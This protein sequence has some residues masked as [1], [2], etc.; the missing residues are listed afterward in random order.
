MTH[1]ELKKIKGSSKNFIKTE[2]GYIDWTF[3]QV[4]MYA[5]YKRA[6]E[7]VDQYKGSA[8]NCKLRNDYKRI[9]QEGDCWLFELQYT[10][11][12]EVMLVTLDGF[13]MT[14]DNSGDEYRDFI[15]GNKKNLLTQT[16]NK[17]YKSEHGDI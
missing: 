10:D 6:L 5:G 4:V 7:I 2:R 3:K 16:R 17:V 13:I 15:R 14:G 12:K 1:E 11:R 9:V 8:E